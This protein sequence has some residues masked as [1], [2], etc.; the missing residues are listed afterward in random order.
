MTIL[1]AKSPFARSL[2]LALSLTVA[3]C[4]LFAIYVYSEKRLDRVS[5]HR[6]QSRLLAD[7][8]RQ[9][10]DDLSRMV[11]TYVLNGN[12]IYKQH[13][14][15]IIE[16]REGR[17]PR[18][19][20]YE[21]IYW[22]LISLDGK[23][24]W[25]GTEQAAPLLERMRQAGFS[26]E[27]FAKVALAKA[28]SDELTKTE[29]LAMALVE[30]VAPDQEIRRLQASQILFDSDY[31]QA[32]LAIMQPINEFYE[33][34]DKRTLQEV[35][36]A[37]RDANWL[38]F[39]FSLTG[40]GMLL[41]LWRT[42][43]NLRNTMGGTVDE[44]Y[45]QITR[46]GQGNF[47]EP[48]TI[49]PGMNNSVLGLLAQTQQHLRQYEED[50]RRLADFDP[51]TGLPNRR[52]LED[53]VDIALSQS[54]R[55]RT[56]LALMFLDL[57]QFKNINDTLG[58]HVGDELLVAVAQRLKS[59]LREQDTVSRLGGDEFVM[60]FADTD[61]AGATQVASK[62]L[63]LASL[64]YQINKHALN[65]S[66]SIGIAMYPAD[67]ESFE[68]LSMHADTAMYR[69]KQAGRNVFRFFKADE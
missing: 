57:D 33:M 7:E 14:L 39:A 45:A 18:P 43:K 26:D 10:S 41:A 3:M 35:R 38:R 5:E 69:A 36:A 17:K 64:P 61:K 22:D 25:T 28:K 66:F 58:H 21:A 59:T 56:T 48:I 8:L 32:K 46:I 27:E 49:A 50:I 37:E 52:L 63:G 47:S 19:V 54:K 51:L 23:L 60:L 4:A 13:Y 40:L 6:Y 1:T 11:R 31:H 16:I 9:S 55:D 34:V 44:V 65:I 29:F 62:L 12:P 24:P 68:T 20:R 2:Q 53:R 67:G 30:S 42:Y 15:D